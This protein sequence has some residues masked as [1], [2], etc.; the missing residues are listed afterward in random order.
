MV[1]VPNG[2]GGAATDVS[3]RMGFC[4]GQTLF[5]DS[6]PRYSRLCLP[7]DVNLNMEMRKCESGETLSENM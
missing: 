2:L 1:M 7:K 5:D 3:W 4:D 6:S